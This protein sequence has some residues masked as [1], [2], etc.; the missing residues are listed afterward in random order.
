[1]PTV[2][3]YLSNG[4]YARLYS[5]HGNAIGKHLSSLADREVGVTA[6][7][8]VSKLMPKKRVIDKKTGEIFKDTTAYAEADKKVKE[9]AYGERDGATQEEIDNMVGGL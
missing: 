4:T 3:V 1:M 5:E 2:G 7:E 8:P 6:P 9:L